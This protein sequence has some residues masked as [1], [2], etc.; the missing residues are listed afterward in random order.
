M[1][2]PTEP[3]SLPWCAYP[4]ASDTKALGLQPLPQVLGIIGMVYMIL[5]NS[6]SSE[7]TLQVYMN[8]GAIVLISCIYAGIWVKYKMKKGWFEPEP[9]ANAIKN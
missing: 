6:P 1:T 2:T 7:M 9:I 3:K 5:N 4:A 8:A